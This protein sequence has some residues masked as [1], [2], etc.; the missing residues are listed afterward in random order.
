MVGFNADYT[1]GSLHLQ[2]TELSTAGWFRRDN[3][4]KLPE[5]LSIARRLIDAWLGER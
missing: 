3:L 2:H 1:G 4:P 5:K